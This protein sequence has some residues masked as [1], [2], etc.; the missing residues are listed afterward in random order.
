VDSIFKGTVQYHSNAYSK[1]VMIFDLELTST[2]GGKVYLLCS[3]G[4][5]KGDFPSLTLRRDV[6]VEARR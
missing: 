1:Q 6:V 4:E 5:G 2:A 3:H